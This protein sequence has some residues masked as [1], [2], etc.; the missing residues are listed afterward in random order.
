MGRTLADRLALL[1]RPVFADFLG[2]GG[3]GGRSPCVRSPTI[4]CGCG[5]TCP[6]AVTRRPAG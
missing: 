2:G 3:P 4:L 5:S 1:N 6:S